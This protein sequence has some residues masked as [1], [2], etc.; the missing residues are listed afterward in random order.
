M[1][2][3]LCTLAILAS[4]YA[5][6]YAGG[7]QNV[8]KATLTST[9]TKDTQTPSPKF[10]EKVEI[11]SSSHYVDSLGWLHIVGEVSYKGKLNAKNVKVI[12]TLYKNGKVIG[13][14][15]AYT[16]LDILKNGEKSPFEIIYTEQANVDCYK[17]QIE[18]E[19][20]PYRD[21][22]VLKDNGYYDHFGHYHIVGEVKNIGNCN[23][24][25]V[26]IISTLYNAK[27]EVIGAEYT[28][29]RIDEL[30]PGE[31]SPFEIIVYHTS[32][33]IDHYKLVTQAT[34]KS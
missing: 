17:L 13:T 34:C 7:V 12:A 28:Y 9:Q 22:L 19:L 1:V 2:F 27:G 3:L 11:L 10:K 21:I 8:Q 33:K 32:G 23:V 30:A 31:T 29:S 26:E 25:N 4:I 5:S 20:I 24:S 16:M 6:V 14:D 15:Y 18:Y